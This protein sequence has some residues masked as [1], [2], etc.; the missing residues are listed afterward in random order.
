M[1]ILIVGLGSLGGAFVQK[2][3]EG[4]PFTNFHL[5][6][7]DRVEEGNIGRHPFFS[8]ADVG[9]FKTDVISNYYRD[10]TEFTFISHPMRIEQVP[11][12]F[13]NKFSVIIATVDS[14]VHPEMA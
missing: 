13:F 14:L 1:E 2:L 4:F 6:D 3:V 5:V 7:H 8:S 12:D 9:L 10:R 11:T